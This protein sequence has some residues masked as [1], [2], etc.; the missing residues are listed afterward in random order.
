MACSALYSVQ[1]FQNKAN[2]PAKLDIYDVA[3]NYWIISGLDPFDVPMYFWRSVYVVIYK[4][5]GYAVARGG[6]V[7]HTCPT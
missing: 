1:N 4:K 6:F 5:L 2:C 7:E 3:T